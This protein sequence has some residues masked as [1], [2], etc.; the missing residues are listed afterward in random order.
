MSIQ[1][2]QS[3]IEPDYPSLSIVRQAQLVGVSRSGLYYEPTI[4]EEDIRIMNVLDEI[5]TT[6]PFYGSRRMVVELARVHGI[7]VCR[8]HVRRLMAEMG[9][10]AIYPKKNKGSEPDVTHKKYPYLLKKLT[11]HSP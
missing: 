5:Y 2:R 9:L 1:D 4:D 8:D 10:E 11:H 3:F 6:Y 7:H